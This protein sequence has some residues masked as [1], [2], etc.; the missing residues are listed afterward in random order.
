MSKAVVCRFYAKGECKRGDYCRFS[1][2]D[3][4]E[5]GTATATVASTAAAANA[6]AT[7]TYVKTLEARPLRQQGKNKKMWVVQ[8]WV[9]YPGEDDSQPSDIL[10][11]IGLQVCSTKEKA[12]TF[13]KFEMI[14][15]FKA[16]V[17]G[18]ERAFVD[19][20]KGAKK[21]SHIKEISKAE[22]DKLIQM[23][24]DML[25]RA[26]EKRETEGNLS[27]NFLIRL[28]ATN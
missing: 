28:V 3:V 26:L 9:T 11:E 10:E 12:D 14:R 16:L 27:V 13:A 22:F 20:A 25:A 7:A 24:T 8:V 6:T 4:K 23:Q 5:K 18:K 21:E 17:N 2:E 1:H 15:Q 19:D